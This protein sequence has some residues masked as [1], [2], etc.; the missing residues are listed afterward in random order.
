MVVVLLL[1]QCAG[2]FTHAKAE[3][4][5]AGGRWADNEEETTAAEMTAEDKGIAVRA[6][7]CLFTVS[8]RNVV[9]AFTWKD[10]F[11]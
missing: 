4:D 11:P 3:A 1:V 2:E 7:V 6:A 8:S 5:D 9:L 10:T